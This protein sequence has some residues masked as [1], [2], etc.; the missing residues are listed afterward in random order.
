MP[1]GRRH[2]ETRREPLQELGRQCDLGQQDQHL[3][4]QAQGCGDALEIG[5]GL[6]RAGDAFEQ[7]DTEGPSL[8]AR[9]ERRRDRDLGVLERR[10]GS[11]RVGRRWSGIGR[12]RDRLERAFVDQPVDDADR[13]ARGLGEKPLVVISLLVEGSASAA[14]TRTRAADIR[15]GSAPARRTPILTGSGPAS[16]G[17]RKAMRS[18]MPRGASVQSASQSMKARSGSRSGGSRHAPRRA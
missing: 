13:A 11:I 14:K 15:A 9:D 12:Q 10:D 6:A 4:A 8:D 7:G 3:S 5:L 2:A 1:F 17:A 18:T 16:S